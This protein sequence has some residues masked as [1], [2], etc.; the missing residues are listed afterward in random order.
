M[1]TLLILFAGKRY[2]V[3]PGTRVDM[4][5]QL[6][7]DV[8]SLSTLYGEKAQQIA[9]FDAEIGWTFDRLYYWGFHVGTFAPPLVLRDTLIDRDI[10]LK[11]LLVG[12][13]VG[14]VPISAFFIHPVLQVQG[15]AG[16]ISDARDGVGYYDLFT[17]VV[18]SAGVEVNVT[19]YIKAGATVSYRYLLNLDPPN[20]PEGDPMGPSWGLFFKLAGY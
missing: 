4:Y 8:A 14:L 11:G 9:F 5:L 7:M 16:F 12:S 17:Y 20:M 15:G 18:P 1:L 2:L 10:P 13:T 19:P 3:G 6:S